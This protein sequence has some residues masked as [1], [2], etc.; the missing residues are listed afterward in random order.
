MVM[1]LLLAGAVPALAEDD[2]RFVTAIA[3]P[4]GQTVVVAEGDLEARSLGSVSVRLY[5]AADI[6]NQTTF[7]MDGVIHARDGALE[8]VLLADVNDNGHPEIIVIARSVG[9]GGYLA[10][11]VFAVADNKLTF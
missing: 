3:L 5:E 6:P 2:N 4:S 9:S 8:K 10:A 7:F 1:G 11:Y